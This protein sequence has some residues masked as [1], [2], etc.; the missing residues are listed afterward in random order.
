VLVREEHVPITGVRKRGI[1]KAVERGGVC[2]RRR[3]GNRSVVV[4]LETVRLERWLVESDDGD[5]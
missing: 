5:P 4:P 2:L 3:T 1:E